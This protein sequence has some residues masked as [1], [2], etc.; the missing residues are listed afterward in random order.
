M[1]AKDVTVTGTLTPITYTITYNLDG[2][3]VSTANPTTY[4][5]ETETF[6]LNNPTKDGATFAGWTAFT[7]GVKVEQMTIKKGSTGNRTYTANWV[8]GPVALG[9]TDSYNADG[10]DERPYLISDSAGWNFLV[11][12]L[13]TT[14]YSNYSGKIFKL[15]DDIT[16]TEMLGINSKEFAGIFDGNGKTLTFDYENA[17]A[18]IIA[19]FKYVKGATIKNL[20][21]A[22]TINSSREDGGNKYI[23]GLI[24]RVNTGET[25]IENCKFVGKLLATDSAD[26]YGGGFVVHNS[27]TLT[28]NGCLYA[29]AELEDGETEPSKSKGTATFAHNGTQGTSTITNSYYTRTL[30]TAQ[31]EQIYTVTADYDITIELAGDSENVLTYDGTIYAGSGKT[32]SLTISGGNTKDG[33]RFMGYTASAGTLT[34]LGGKYSLTMPE[35]NVTISAEFVEN[36]SYIDADGQNATT[37]DYTVLTS[38][39]TSLTAGTYVVKENVT[40]SALTLTGDVNLI[41]CDGATLSVTGN[42]SGATHS[43]EYN[44]DG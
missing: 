36:I 9:W 16:V 20:T 14:N 10:S 2:G 37:S 5:V 25:T 27:G 30:G 39:M 41:L 35:G 32:L 11:S 19:P 43:R 12:E 21:V 28:I 1:P 38:S 34:E 15:T 3:E 23:G 13:Q 22:G 18:L 17:T 40:L 4:T 29:P 42:V 33:Y 26:A 24:Q 8:Q 6:T 44:P 31:G 7:G